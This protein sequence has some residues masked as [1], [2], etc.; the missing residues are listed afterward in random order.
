MSQP[1]YPPQ[2]G[3]DPRRRAIR[4]R[5]GTPRSAPTTPPGSSPPPGGAADQTQQF[6]QP[7]Y[8]QQYGQLRQSYGQH[9]Q[10][11]Y[12]QPPRQPYGSLQYGQHPEYGPSWPQ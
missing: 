6:G 8:G 2:G 12:G 11:Q 5:T 4:A 1:P 9:G 10:P 7:P 3:N